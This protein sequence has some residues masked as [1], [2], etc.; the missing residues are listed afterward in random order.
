[1]VI[2]TLSQSVWEFAKSRV[3][4]AMRPSVVY[5]PTCKARVNFS[6]LCAIVPI[7]VP[8][9]QWSANCLTLT[10]KGRTNFSTIFQKDFSVLLNICKLQ[11]NL[12]N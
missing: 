10:A 3:I 12:G 2:F 9:C 11:E 7:N 5:V 4:R 8:T 6:F 1:M